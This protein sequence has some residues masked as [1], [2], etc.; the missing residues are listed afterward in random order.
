MPRLLIVL[1]L[2]WW[3]NVTRADERISTKPLATLPAD[4][5]AQIVAGVDEF[6]LRK[7]REA[8]KARTGYWRDKKQFEENRILLRKLIGLEAKRFQNS[9]G[10]L[11]EPEPLAESDAFSMHHA[12]WPV[13]PHPAPHLSKSPALWG[14]AIHLRPKKLQP[15][16][17]SSNTLVIIIPDADELPEEWLPLGVAKH[18]DDT[19]WRETFATDIASDGAHVLVMSTISREMHRH[20]NAT[21]SRREYLHR[22]AF[23]LGRTLTGYE[24]QMVQS[25]IDRFEDCD[26][27][28][29]CG[30]GEG[31][32]IALMVGAIDERIDS[33]IVG[34]YFGQH[35]PVW[36]E[37]LSRQVFGFDKRFCDGYLATLI[38]PREF[39]FFTDK[40]YSIELSGS[41]GAPAK[42]SSTEIPNSETDE[43]LDALYREFGF[44]AKETSGKAGRF[45][46]VRFELMRHGFALGESGITS[47]TKMVSQGQ[48]LQAAIGDHGKEFS[49]NRQNAGLNSRPSIG[50]IR[51]LA[52]A[53]SDRMFQC[54]DAY[55]Q[56]L[57]SESPY[58]REQYLNIGLARNDNKQGT[59]AVDTSSPTAYE[60]SIGPF[61]TDFR[62][63]VIG[64][65]DED[66][67]APNARSKPAMNGKN[68]SGHEVTL[69]VFPEFDAYGVLLMPNDLDPNTKH[70]V[71]VCQHGLEGRPQDT[72]LGDHRA[73]HNYAAR[74]AEKGYIV[75]AP[76][77]LYIG[78]DNFR[79]LQ[80]KAYPLGKTLFSIVG[81][82]HQQIIRWLKS[83]P[84][85]DPDRIAFYGLSY[86]GKSAM[87]LPAM[88]PDYCLSIC[89][90]DFNDWVWKNA[91]S[92]SRYSYIGTG[93]YEIFEF[94]LGKKFNYA[95]MAALI[96]PRPF[97]VE[98]GHFDGVA[99]DDRVAKEFAKVRFL[100]QAR[101]KLKDRCEIEFFDGPHTINGVGTFEFLDRHLRDSRRK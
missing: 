21:M 61:R 43:S 67:L 64:W 23:E 93:E 16:Q 28:I 11:Y 48:L 58:E 6:L 60:N 18:D 77:N 3:T 24:V 55:N 45:Q 53:R 36:S 79:T 33:T 1:I 99:P 8:D 75:F 38:S 91:S 97:M 44:E 74:L 42:W 25:L 41:G 26:N 86:G 35:G 14:E 15:R 100:Y 30:S 50:E 13:L 76:Q 56:L 94:G 39:V 87:R 80:R 17:S 7:L 81:A 62:E 32:M 20:R 68:W 4:P 72:I 66:L 59:N 31:G 90:A 71:V 78:K 83:I 10:M 29:V 52:R 2:L 9:Q 73:Y 82:Q 69:D 89:S 57:L 92:R 85:V 34:N 84:A 88:L 27:V 70:P 47:K 19:K 96:A 65:F 37:P 22:A 5:A 98:R 51:A 101:L 46:Q 54:I 49:A 12:R 63:N 40:A 95:E